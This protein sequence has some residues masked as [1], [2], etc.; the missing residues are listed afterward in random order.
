MT[1]SRSACVETSLMLDESYD[2]VDVPHVAEPEIAE[3][4]VAEFD[5]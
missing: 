2:G 5:A 1:S 3:Y 4:D